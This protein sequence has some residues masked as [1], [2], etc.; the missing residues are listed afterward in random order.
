MTT[1]VRRVRRKRRQSPL[2][3]GTRFFSQRTAIFVGAIC[4]GFALTSLFLT[5]TPRAF[6]SWRQSRLLAQANAMLQ[7]QDYEG[8]TRIAQHILR[9]RPASLPAFQIL[10]EATEKQ[11]RPETVAW[12]SQIARALPHN[13]PAH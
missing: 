7:K 4:V 12:R 11:N 8:A 2:Q 5:Y 1:K 10:A 13:L 3:G 9:L 6:G